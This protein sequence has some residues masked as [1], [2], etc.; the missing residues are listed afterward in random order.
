MPTYANLQLNR[1]YLVQENENEE[2][3][4]VQP[5][6][7]TANAVLVFLHSDNAHTSFWRKKNAPLLE[8][9]DELSDEQITEYETV[10]A[11]G[12]EVYEI[13]EEEEEDWDE[14]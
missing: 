10:F 11:T 2:L 5:V 7:E 14:Q 8:I 4:L 13:T 3:Q 6:M 1:F 12:G 9:A